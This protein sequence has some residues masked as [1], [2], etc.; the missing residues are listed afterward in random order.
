M[1]QKKR[2]KRIRMMPHLSQEDKIE[3]A[4][5]FNELGEQ[6]RNEVGR[7]DNYDPTLA[8]MICLMIASHSTSMA[9]LCAKYK[10]YGMPNEATIW[11]WMHTYPEFLDQYKKAKQIQMH[12]FASQMLD[13][14]DDAHPSQE[15]INHAKLRVSARQYLMSKY[16]P[17]D[18]GDSLKAQETI[19]DTLDKVQAQLD[20][21]RP[22][23]EREF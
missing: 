11:S 2:K 8:R 16:A 21:I 7:P 20:A 23:Y 5:M 19:S 17:K 22:S 4:K 15:S 10:D 9:K 18:F 14:A 1:E 6:I 3:A 12:I 13:I